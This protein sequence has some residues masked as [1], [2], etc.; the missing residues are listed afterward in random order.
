MKSYMKKIVA[1][2][3]VAAMSLT[4]VAC[5]SSSDK[6]VANYSGGKITQ[7]DFYN[8]L[9]TSQSGKST[10]ANMIIQGALENQYGSKVSEQNVNDE[11]SK[12]GSQYGSNFSLI[13]QSNGYTEATFKKSLRTNL[14]IEAAMKDLKQIS[15]E[16]EQKA[17]ESYQPKVTV[18]HILV[19]D[20]NTAK[21][22]ITDLN[23][24]K[25]FDELA[26]QYS[27]DTAT[28]ENG[29]KL[30]EFDNTDTSLDATF[31]EAAFKLQTNQYTTEPVK[32]KFGY[33]IIKMANNPG[34]GELKDHKQDIDN[35]VYES[36]MK[37][38]SVM[39]SVISTVL[40][41]ANPSIKDKDLS[42]ALA[43]YIQ[44][45]SSSTDLSSSA[46]E[47]S[48]SQATESSSSEQPQSSQE[49][50]QS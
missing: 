49:S 40:T 32:T 47:G 8:Q 5:S 39:Q 38:T 13:L 30:P 27:T 20:E 17:W 21:Q 22:I 9:K 11:Y 37:D 44:S 46:S 25:N 16:D 14:L 50:S 31:K 48:Q 26:K 18:Q 12:Y 4:L 2:A 10:L 23:S 35:Q 3:G 6:T 24:G 1:G 29:G 41:K 34:K 36:W 42:D 45:A 33:H 43:A 7:D 15:S 28:K 19:S